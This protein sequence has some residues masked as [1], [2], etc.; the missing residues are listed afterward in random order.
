M[1]EA[2]GEFQ[3]SG[4][5]GVVLSERAIGPHGELTVVVSRQFNFGSLPLAKLIFTLA[6][7]VA[8][9]EDAPLTDTSTVGTALLVIAMQ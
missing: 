1:R 5:L 2:Q 9:R 3:A 8:G 6:S 7:P 4:G